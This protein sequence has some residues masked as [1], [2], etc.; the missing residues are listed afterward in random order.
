MYQYEAL[1]YW[2]LEETRVPKVVGSNPSAVYWIDIFSNLF[3]VKFVM[4]VWKDE[5]KRKRPGMVYHIYAMLK[6]DMTSPPRWGNEHEIGYLKGPVQEL[7]WSIACD[8]L[9]Q[10]KCSI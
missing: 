6:F 9:D 1:V 10:S 8:F 3:V 4:F 5:N 2:L 7:G